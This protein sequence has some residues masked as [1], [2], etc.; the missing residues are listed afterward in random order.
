[1]D[2]QMVKKLKSKDF[3]AEYDK[4]WKTGPPVKYSNPEIWFRQT[5]AEG[6]TTRIT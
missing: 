1:V 5:Y 4:M 2:K 6:K 3:K